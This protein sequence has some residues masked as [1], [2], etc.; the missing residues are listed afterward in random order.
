MG[1]SNIVHLDPA[2]LRA[3]MQRHPEADYLL[4][5]VRQPGEYTA[6]HIPGAL[7]M[8]LMQLE[9][10]LF[11][12]P[13]DRD[14]IFY[15]HSGGRSAAAAALALD[16]EITRKTIF[17]LSGGI[18]AWDGMTLADYPR[19]AVFDRDVTTEALL[20][21]AM[22]LEK[23]AWNFYREVCRHFADAPWI[24][25]FGDLAADEV[26]HA[27]SV[28][29]FLA[30]DR[31]PS[32]PF[33]PFFD[34]LPGTILEGGFDLQTAVEHIGAVAADQDRPLFE[35]AL[36]IEAAAYDLYRIMAEREGIPQEAREALRSI[37]QA[38]KAHIRRLV[39]AMEQSAPG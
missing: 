29:R 25:A 34:R 16:A 27:R 4:V 3:Y 2:R 17:N 24:E 22:D 31:R 30:S 38:E 36:S 8:P 6:A 18:L 10:K 5:D 11:E 35:L 26:A 12:L 28:Y 39:R 14:L 7:L 23:G 1:R 9:A 21:K 20:A 15:C 13:S 33:E 32:E 37:A 19:T